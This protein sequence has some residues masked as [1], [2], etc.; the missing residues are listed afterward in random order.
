MKTILKLVVAA[1]VMNAAYRCG[2]AAWTYYEFKDATQQ[3]AIFGTQMSTNELQGRILQKASDLDVP[4]APENL[5]VRRDG[6]RTTADAAYTQP[7]EVLPSYRYPVR[8]SFSVEGINEIAA[9]K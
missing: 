6:A 7:V 3:L 5:N 2:M 9:A 4:L 1:L 8:F